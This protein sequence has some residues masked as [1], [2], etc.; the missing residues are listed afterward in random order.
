VPQLFNA[1]R[2]GVELRWPRL[3]QVEEAC[4]ALPA[5]AQAVPERQPDAP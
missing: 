5:F 2:F 1:R 4:L 3:V